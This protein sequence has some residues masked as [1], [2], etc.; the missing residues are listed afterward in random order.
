MPKAEHHHQRRLYPVPK[1]QT[2]GGD[3]RHHAR[4]RAVN[5]V[6]CFGGKMEYWDPDMF[7]D[8][9]RLASFDVLM[10]AHKR[11]RR[12]KRHTPGT[13]HFEANLLNSIEKL[14]YILLNKKYKPSRFEVFTVYE[15]K[16]R[17]VQAPAH[18]DK[19]VQHALVDFYLYDILTASL[20]RDN[21]AVQ[22]GRGTHDGLNRIKH[23][24]RSYFRKRKGRDEIERQADGLPHRPMDE[25]DYAQGWVLKADIKQFFHSINHD[26]V[27]GMLRERV[28]DQRVLELMYTYIDVSEGLPLGYQTSQLLALMYLDPFDHWVKEKLGIKYYGRYMDDFYL[29]HEDKRYLKRCLREIEDYMTSLGLTL[30]EKTEITPLRNG[31]DFLGFRLYLTETGKVVQKLRQSSAKRMKRRIKSWVKDQ[32]NGKADLKHI[33]DSYTAWNAHAA[34]GH[35]RE[36]RIKIKRQ[37]TANFKDIRKSKGSAQ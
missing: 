5:T 26:I 31:I 20:I 22:I 3:A 35:T 29:I 34:Y 36:L 2:H 1:G 17:M 32:E 21:Y 4:W 24:M 33:W 8:F 13:A 11:A 25:W 14:S 28:P 9:E 18:V 6:F 19:V 30:N 15:P 23:H 37:M 10:K 16:Q 7:N 12:G 27:K